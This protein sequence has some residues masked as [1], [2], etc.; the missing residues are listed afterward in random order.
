MFFIS[1]FTNAMQAES[2][3]YGELEPSLIAGNFSMIFLLLLMVF[4]SSLGLLIYYVVHAVKNKSFDKNQRL[5]WI[6]ILILANGIG[7]IIYFFVEIAPRKP[8]IVE[9]P[10]EA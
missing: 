3:G 4:I 1:F 10:H 7:N 6:L 8:K 9:E 2:N 5:M